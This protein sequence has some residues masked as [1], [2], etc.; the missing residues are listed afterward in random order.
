V[1]DVADG[2]G[3]GCDVP[4]EPEDGTADAQTAA[5]P[6]ASLERQT[7]FWQ[8]RRRLRTRRQLRADGRDTGGGLRTRGRRPTDEVDDARRMRQTAVT[9]AASCGWLPADEANSA[10]TADG[11]GTDDDGR[12]DRRRTR[13]GGPRRRQAAGAQ[14]AD[15][16]GTDDGGR[17]RRG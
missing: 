4:G 15:G 3:E 12:A 17:G 9:P 5:T 13:S 2:D 6:A 16:R 14:T 7:V 10:Q 11:R 1:A 8:A